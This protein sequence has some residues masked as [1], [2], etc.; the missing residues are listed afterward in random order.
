MYKVHGKAFNN[1]SDALDFY[2]KNFQINS[3]YQNIE[4]R[5]SKSVT[6]EYRL[7]K[8]EAL[9]NTNLKMP[10]FNFVSCDEPESLSDKSKAIS[11]AIDSHCPDLTAISQVEK[12]INNLSCKVDNYSR[13]E[14]EFLIKVF[15]FK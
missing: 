7:D 4:T 9:M 8:L 13:I 10:I 12:L 2:I 1:A 3:N 5:C 15:F 6:K 14:G 11:I